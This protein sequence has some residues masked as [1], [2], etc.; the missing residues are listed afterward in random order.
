MES[1]ADLFAR[2]RRDARIEGLSVRAL[3]A[4]HGVHPRTV[5]Q[6]LESAT[7][8]ER[9]LRQ[10]VSWRLEP[11]KPAIDAMLTVDTPAPRKQRH[12]ARR[13]LARLIEE[14]GAEE[15]S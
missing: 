4:R 9:K 11:F 15:Q 14:H 10:G 3:A 5:R 7:R 1:R 6:A 12:T 8:P 13:I 2:I